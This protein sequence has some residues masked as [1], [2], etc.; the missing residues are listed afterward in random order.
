MVNDIFV[1]LP[2]EDLERSKRFFSQLGYSFNQQFT[3]EKAACLILGDHIYAMLLDKKFFNTFTTKTIADTNTT[4]EVITALM[5]GSK[6]EVDRL[7]DNALKAGAAYY[8][9]TEDMGFMY[10]RTFQ[11]PDGHLWEVGWMDPSHVE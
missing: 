10:Q 4:V 9:D 11:D 3:D 7:A 8:R 2:V 6:D 5:V 1:N